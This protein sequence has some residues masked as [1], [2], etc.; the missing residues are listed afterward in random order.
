MS[1]RSTRVGSVYSGYNTV[2]QYAGIRHVEGTY[3]AVQNVGSRNWHTWMWTPALSLPSWAA[4]LSIIFIIC[5]M[6]IKHDTCALSSSQGT[7]GLT[8]AVC[9]GLA[10]SQFT[11]NA[12]PVIIMIM[13]LII[14]SNT[15]IINTVVLIMS[16]S[17]SQSKGPRHPTIKWMT[18]H[19][20]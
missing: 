13:I 3:I 14:T 6:R 18:W 9:L 16:E 19:H 4:S 20:F 1:S 15:I 11:V 2:V 5:K 17:G 10:Q 12:V 8:H 7:R